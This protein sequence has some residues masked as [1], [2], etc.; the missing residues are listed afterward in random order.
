MILLCMNF[1]F[2][3][4]EW[5]EAWCQYHRNKVATGSVDQ[6]KMQFLHFW[7][8]KEFNLEIY[9][10]FVDLKK[11]F[12]NAKLSLLRSILEWGSFPSQLLKKL[13]PYYKITVALDFNGRLI[14]DI[15]TNKGVKQQCPISSTIFYKYIDTYFGYEKVKL[16]WKEVCRIG[17]IKIF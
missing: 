3:L 4:E 12:D 8:E 1:R 6:A 16:F 2:A 11:S 9:Q 7:K 14:V 17:P 10:V 13:S 5:I 15:P